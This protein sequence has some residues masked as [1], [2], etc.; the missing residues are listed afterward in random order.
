MFAL[1]LVLNALGIGLFCW[2][3]FEL[4]VYALPFFTAVTVGMMALHSG[5]GVVG[6]LLVGIGTAALT[7]V[8]GQF[9]F[10][11]AKPMILRAVVAA[12]F[13]VPAGIAGYHLIFGLSRIGVP[14]LLWREIFAC[15][16]SAIIGATAWMRITVFVRP[17]SR[18]GQAR[19]ILRQFSRPRRARDDPLRLRRGALPLSD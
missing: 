12:V 14:S 5:A 10:A 15:L 2:L 6:A 9:A 13:V 11:I 18:A 1:G 8:T 17:R 16:G 3:I 19:T 4:A 7:L